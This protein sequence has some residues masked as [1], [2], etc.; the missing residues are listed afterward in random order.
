MRA[1]PVR[2]QSAGDFYLCSVSVQFEAGYEGRKQRKDRGG[3][4]ERDVK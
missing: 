3:N 2:A 4:L 1:V